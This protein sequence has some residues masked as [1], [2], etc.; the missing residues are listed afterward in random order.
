MTDTVLMR[1][2][3]DDGYTIVEFR[4]TDFLRFNFHRVEILNML[5]AG[6]IREFIYSELFASPYDEER[7]RGWFGVEDREKFRMYVSFL[8]EMDKLSAKELNKLYQQEDSKPKIF[9]NCPYVYAISCASQNIV[10]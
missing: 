2:L 9:T 10:K 7:E 6:K 8:A 1:K 3:A 5:M 4:H